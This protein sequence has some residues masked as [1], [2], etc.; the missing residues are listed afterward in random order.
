MSR[1]HTHDRL[2][3]LCSFLHSSTQNFEQKRDCLQSTSVKN[4][5]P[6]VIKVI[7]SLLEYHF[8]MLFYS[9]FHS[10]LLILGDLTCLFC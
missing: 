10:M 4:T 9:N 1:L 2:L 7:F 3:V 8:V 5:W 6:L